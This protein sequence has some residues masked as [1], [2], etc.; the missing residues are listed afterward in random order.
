M[1]Y[2]LDMTLGKRIQRAR[3]RL[4]PNVSQTFVA[5]ALGVSKQAVSNWE[6]DVD[7]PTGD[8]LSKL[9][10]ILKVR[11]EWLLDEDGPMDSL[12]EI[13]QNAVDALIKAIRRRAAA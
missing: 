8:K 1:L 2:D 9:R 4:R 5:D 13:E 11:Y 3:K 7:P 12:S 10:K 6:R